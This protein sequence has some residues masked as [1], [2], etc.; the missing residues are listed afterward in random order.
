MADETVPGASTYQLNRR[1]YGQVVNR[2]PS[3]HAPANGLPFAIHAKGG[4]NSSAF[5]VDVDAVRANRSAVFGEALWTQEGNAISLSDR[6]DWAERVDGKASPLNRP[7]IRTTAVTGMRELD[8]VL[9]QLGLQLTK[10]ISAFGQFSLPENSFYVFFIGDQN[11]PL[12]EIDPN[13]LSSASVID[14]DSETCVP[15]A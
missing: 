7:I 5:E 11:D 12:R 15:G 3:F 6:G 13:E 9:D 4:W 1:L 14:P 8:R 10:S 2:R